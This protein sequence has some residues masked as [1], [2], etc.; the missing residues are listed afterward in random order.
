MRTF[1]SGTRLGWR[2]CN[3]VCP[4][5]PPLCL[6]VQLLVPWACGSLTILYF[7]FQCS[8]KAVSTEPCVVANGNRCLPTV[9][10]HQPA[11]LDVAQPAVSCQTQC[12]V[13]SRQQIHANSAL[14]VYFRRRQMLQIVHIPLLRVLRGPMQVGQQHVTFAVPVNIRQA[15]EEQRIVMFAVRANIQ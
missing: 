12:L 1:Q 11:D 6:L 2:P 13:H 3:Q 7:P 9:I 15:P 4:Q 10:W 14:L 8:T 5:L